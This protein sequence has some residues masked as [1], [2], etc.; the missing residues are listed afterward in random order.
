VGRPS[1]RVA[2]TSSPPKLARRSTFSGPVSTFVG[3]DIDPIKVE[4]H[5]AVVLARMICEPCN[6]E[7]LNQLEEKVRPFLPC[8]PQR[9]RA[10]VSLRTSESCILD[11]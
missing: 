1:S 10:S 11:G 6:N 5:L 3:D 8:D 7:W 9:Y 2:S 4:A